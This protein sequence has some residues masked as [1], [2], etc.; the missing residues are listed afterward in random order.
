MKAI[1]DSPKEMTLLT[2]RVADDCL[3]RWGSVVF[4]RSGAL[5][6]HRWFEDDEIIAASHGACYTEE[7][8]EGSSGCPTNSP[9]CEPDT[10]E[11]PTNVSGCGQP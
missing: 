11:C 1:N 10:F 6:G 5:A 3:D 7:C 4:E 2:G 8:E 9:D